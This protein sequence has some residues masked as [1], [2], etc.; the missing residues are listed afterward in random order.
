MKQILSSTQICVKIPGQCDIV[1]SIVDK[2]TGKVPLLILYNILTILLINN[3]T[4]TQAIQQC[5]G[6]A[7]CLNS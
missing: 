6:V 7:P 2:F 3:T 1:E 5:G 4:S